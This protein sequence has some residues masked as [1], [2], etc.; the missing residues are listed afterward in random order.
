MEMSTSITEAEDVRLYQA[1]LGSLAKNLGERNLVLFLGSGAS[2]GAPLAGRNRSLSA[3]GLARKLAE[4]LTEYHWEQ[5]IETLCDLCIKDVSRGIE[6]ACDNRCGGRNA[7][8][9][10]LRAH[11]NGLHSM[12]LEAVS[13]VANLDLA[14]VAW[15]YETERAR[16]EL[17][18]VL[19]D[20]L[21]GAQPKPIHRLLLSLPFSAIYTTNYDRLVETSQ[22][23]GRRLEVILDDGK[24]MELYRP[25]KLREKG[26]IPYFKLHGSIE[27][28]QAIITIEDKVKWHISLRNTEVFRQ[29]RLD[30][31]MRPALFVGYNL[32][33]MDLMEVIYSA[34]FTKFGGEPSAEPSPSYAVVPNSSV[35]LKQYWFK[36]YNIRIIDRD[37]EEFF[38]DLVAAYKKASKDERHRSVDL[39]LEYPDVWRPFNAA[40]QSP[41][42]GGCVLYGNSTL[43]AV[44]ATQMF[45]R[46][47]R[48]SDMPVVHLN[49][50]DN[51]TEFSI[52]LHRF[53]KLL[54]DTARQLDNQLGSE[55]DLWTKLN[56][57]A[58][59]WGTNAHSAV[60]TYWKDTIGQ[61][62]PLNLAR[63]Q[64]GTMTPEEQKENQEVYEDNYV[65][66]AS[67]TFF[68]NLQKRRDKRKLSAVHHRL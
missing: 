55:S 7:I 23:G 32:L 47:V 28:S 59:E 1:M 43:P 6:G 22:E 9:D 5:K 68:R 53:K 21:E 12:V 8:I 3:G 26:K 56:D 38:S 49:L 50:L 40:L 20:E 36:Q 60:A 15:I 17:L 2:E 61:A 34:F 30:V 19:R 18:R 24:F 42:F 45:N 65:E 27:A 66:A 25:E 37:P 35:S 10:T 44:I 31:G 11:L 16:S 46:Y 63:I 64:S 33:D 67:R 48:S 62:D 39:A 58:D 57:R 54:I 14:E 4:E 52:G 41:G 29:L 13:S 51:A